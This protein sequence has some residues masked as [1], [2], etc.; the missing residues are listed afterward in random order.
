MFDNTSKFEENIDTPTDDEYFYGNENDG[1]YRYDKINNIESGNYI[2]KSRSCTYIKKYDKAI[3][4]VSNLRTNN[5]TEIGFDIKLTIPL[6]EYSFNDNDVIYFEVIDNN[7]SIVGK[8]IDYP[9]SDLNEFITFYKDN[10][11]TVF[12]VGYEYKI[13]MH[14][15]YTYTITQQ[16]VVSALKDSGN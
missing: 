9:V 7:N 6:D 8:S 1:L 14:I 5:D 13:V 10:V 11:E 15:K 16:K 4:L 2:Y 12:K 3:D